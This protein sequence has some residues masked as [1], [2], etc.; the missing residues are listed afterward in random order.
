MENSNPNQWT[1]AT[2]EAYLQF[3]RFFVPRREAQIALMTALLPDYDRPFTVLELACGEGLL[4][5]SIL[6]HLPH[7]RVIGLDGSD[8]MRRRAADYL[9]HFGDRF[10]VQAFDLGAVGWRRRAQSVDAVVSSL[11]IHHLDDP[12]KAQLYRDVFRLL[13]PGGV[14]VVADIIQPV[15][16]RATSVAA[17]AFDA[18]VRRRVKRLAD[19]P[20]AYEHFRDEGWNLFRYP[21]PMD[22]PAPIGAHLAWLTAAGF[23]EVDVYWVDSGHAIYGGARPRR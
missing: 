4:A 18:A 17:D 21:D 16:A 1:E 14:F 23:T 20:A 10:T 5:E 9:R 7:S 8:V 2:S 15:G 6:T 12:G 3:S 13:A 19:S 22:M 11:T